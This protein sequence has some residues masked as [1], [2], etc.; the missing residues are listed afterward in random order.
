MGGIM[1]SALILEKD[2]AASARVARVLAG[3]GYVTAPVRT[4]DEAL[5]AAGAIRFDVIVTCTARRDHDRRSFTGELKRAAPQAAVLLIG[6]DREARGSADMWRHPGI[7]AVIPRPPS[8]DTLR[9]IVEF[10]IDGEGLQVAYVR[11]AH[12]RR[13]R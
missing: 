6:D 3:L 1:K 2:G 9:R 5:N 4:P 11:P 8:V 10:G 7:S 12:E 13:R